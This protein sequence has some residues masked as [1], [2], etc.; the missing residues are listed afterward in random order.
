ME[1]TRS[2]LVWSYEATESWGSFGIRALNIRN[3][4]LRRIPGQESPGFVY[5]RL[6]EDDQ[7]HFENLQ[8]VAF[9]FPVYIIPLKG[10]M[11]RFVPIS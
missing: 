11:L 1:E 5:R 8:R 7:V 6:T 10:C 9:T 4:S 2:S 3:P